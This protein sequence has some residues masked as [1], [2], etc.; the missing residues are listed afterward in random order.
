M[1]NIEILPEFVDIKK[2]FVNTP[3][4]QSSRILPAHTDHLF[5]SELWKVIDLTGW[6]IGCNIDMDNGGNGWRKP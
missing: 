5:L 6:I 3:L 1:K 2:K 4:Y